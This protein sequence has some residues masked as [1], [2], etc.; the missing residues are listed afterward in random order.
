MAE[1]GL[2]L[3]RRAEMQG[4]SGLHALFIGIS[5]YTKLTHP[6]DEPPGEG[7]AALQK[8]RS[9]ALSAFRMKERVL[10]LDAGNRLLK[11]LKTVRFLSAPTPEEI[12]AEPRLQQ[13]AGDFP[14]FSAV[15][16]VIRAWRRDMAFNQE[17]QGLF[18]FSGHGVRIMGNSAI[19]LAADFDPAGEVLLENAFDFQNIYYAMAPNTKYP[20]IGRTQFYFI[21]ACRNKPEILKEIEDPR[22]SPIFDVRPPDR[23]DRKAPVA[24]ATRNGGTAAAIA[25]DSTEFTA[26][27]LWALEMGSVTCQT[28]P[29]RKDAGWA[30]SYDSMKLCLNA[31]NPALASRVEFTGLGAETVLTFRTDP[32]PVA[33]SMSF[34][35]DTADGKVAWARLIHGDTDAE[36]EAGRASEGNLWQVTVPSGIYRLKVEAQDGSFPA[37]RST[38]EPFNP[39]RSMPWTVTLGGS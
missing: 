25:G 36:A 28:L 13:E 1:T 34:V 27:I 31:S 4:A 14:N 10:S 17:E 20:E 9:P 8:L 5:D 32:P 29:G 11:P 19:L 38:L 12:A 21:D 15:R 39:G 33:I 23:D 26:G 35:P 7:M 37:F 6:E 22:P 24:Y 3:D 16:D 30:I 2:I 18:Q